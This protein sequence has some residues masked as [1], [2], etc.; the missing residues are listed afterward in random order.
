LGLRKDVEE[1]VHA[2][3]TV[4]GCLLQVLAFIIA[5]FGIVA[6][7]GSRLAGAGFLLAAAGAFIVGSL[8]ARHTTSL[9]CPN[10]GRLSKYE[11]ETCQ[12][13]GLSF[14]END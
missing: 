12:H 8:R 2:I 14:Y 5:L 6:L 7:A 13:C 10:C 11:A 9:K 1:V 3:H 4:Q